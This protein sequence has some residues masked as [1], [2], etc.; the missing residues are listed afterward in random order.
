MKTAIYARIST[1]VN[2]SV[3][4]QL[5]D[6]QSLA[7]RRRFEIVAEYCDE[8][9]SGAQD[10]R[11]GLNQLLADA[12]AGKFSVVLVW[13]LDRLSRSLAHLLRLME[14]FRRLSIELVSFSE[15]LDFTTTTGKLLFQILSAF[16]EFERDCIR[17][18]VLAG[19]RNARA[20]GKR[21]GR[22]PKALDFSTMVRLRQGGCSWREIGRSLGVGAST[23]RRAFMHSPKV[24]A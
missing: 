15:G 18:R 12:E 1:T 14:R 2:Q 20:K 23:A 13:K 4:M 6:L 24:T 11:P 7:Q 16:A 9:I 10:S 21:I 5:R 22:P 3:E 17:E 8:G 19:M